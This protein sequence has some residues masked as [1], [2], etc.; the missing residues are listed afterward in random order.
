MANSE[1]A[2]KVYAVIDEQSIRTLVRPQLFDIFNIQSES[3]SYTLFSCSGQ[4][5][6]SGRGVNALAV[7]ALDGSCQFNLSTFIECDEILDNKWEIPTPE[8][9]DKYLHL[10][11]IADHLMPLDSKINIIFF[12]RRDL[13][14]AHHVLEQRIGPPNVSNAQ[15]PH[16]GWVIVE[17]GCL[18]RTNRS[19]VAV[20]NKIAVMSDGRTTLST[21]CPNNIIV[22]EN[23][24]KQIQ[25]D[26]VF[27]HPHKMNQSDKTFFQ[28]SHD[29]DKPGLSVNDEEFLSIMN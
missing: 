20:A 16:L 5:T 25:Y 12:N 6:C 11:D 26:A 21:P 18:E 1:Q 4:S 28:I 23:L 10:Q 13:G 15:K 24:L 19:D 27:I 8:I 29:D 2:I 7:E 3:E 9:A 17:E 22:K 14:D